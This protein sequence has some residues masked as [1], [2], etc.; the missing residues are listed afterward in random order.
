MKKHKVRSGLSHISKN[1]PGNYQNKVSN[2]NKTMM[3]NRSEPE[4][5]MVGIKPLYPYQRN[6]IRNRY[7]QKRIAGNSCFY[8]QMQ[9]LMKSTLTSASRTIP[10]GQPMKRTP[11]NKCRMHG[12]YQKINPEYKHAANEYTNVLKHQKGHPLHLR[13]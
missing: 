3:A 12:I 6:Q 11:G 7:D 8:I 4:K 10:T 5:T 2:Y 9:Q 13:K 1:P